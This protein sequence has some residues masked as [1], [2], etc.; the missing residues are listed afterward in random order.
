MTHAYH[1]KP[2][3]TCRKEETIFWLQER[4][5]SMPKNAHAI[6]VYC[7]DGDA[8][9]VCECQDD[10]C[11]VLT[12]LYATGGQDLYKDGLEDMWRIEPKGGTE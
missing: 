9:L 5:H 7:N 10:P 2:S 6:R 8:L 1:D 3:D 4:G 12:L 11:Q